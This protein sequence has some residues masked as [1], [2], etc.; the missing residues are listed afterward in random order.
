MEKVFEPIRYIEMSKGC[1]NGQRGAPGWAGNEKYDPKTMAQRNLLDVKKDYEKI[2]K[3]LR[4]MS[5]A[6]DERLDTLDGLL[7]P[8]LRNHLYHMHASI[9][10]AEKELSAL[11]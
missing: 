3:L 5:G 7:S 8:E 9:L 1:P 10:Y 4:K 6:Q 11:K 2:V